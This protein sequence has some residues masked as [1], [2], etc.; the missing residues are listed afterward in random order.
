MAKLTEKEQAG[1][2][3]LRAEMPDDLAMEIVEFRREKKAKIT[4]RIAKALLKQYKA[5]GNV[6]EA[7]TIH[8]VR[9]W[10]GFEAE[11]VKPKGRTFHDSNNP[12]PLKTPANYG[13]AEVV[14]PPEP[15]SEEERARRSEMAARARAAIARAV[16]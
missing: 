7:A 1:Y 6:E 15:M 14:S 3:I 11:W 5:F 16:H 8:M 4:A 10:V 9:N 12:M 2:D 13:P